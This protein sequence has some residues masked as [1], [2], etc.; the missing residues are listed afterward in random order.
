VSARWQHQLQ[1]EADSMDYDREQ[2]TGTGS[3]GA[4]QAG[5][6]SQ[7]TGS[8]L[9]GNVGGTPRT[10]GLSGAAGA[11]G[12]GTGGASFG[13]DGTRAGSFD[14]KFTGED[15]GLK[16]RVSDKLDEGRE[17]VGEKLEEGRDRLGHAVD[18]GRNRIADQLERVGD[19]IEDRAR[20]ME[21]AGGVQRRAGQVARRT[22]EA[23]DSSADYLRNHDAA[24]MRDDLETAIRER[25][26]LSVGMALGAGFLLAR[27]M[28]D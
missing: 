8:G 6:T 25:P 12:T 28:R 16:D 22:S 9:G 15:E 24:E 19:Q 5:G 20:A 14:R 18:T 23:L 21:D 4:E 11:A 17:L 13:D 2:R 27:I 1:K 26:L 3:T 10:E 7:T